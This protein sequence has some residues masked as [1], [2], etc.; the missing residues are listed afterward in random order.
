MNIRYMSDLH[1]EFGFGTSIPE[2]DILVLAGDIVDG[3][4]RGLDKLKLICSNFNHVLMVM[5]NHEHYVG[6]FDKTYDLLK[7]NLPDNV[8]IL[9]NNYAEIDGQRFIGCT[10]WSYMN[11]VDSYLAKV[12]M[13]DYSYIKI[14]DKDIYRK[15]SPK[16][17]IFEHVRS[18]SWLRSNIKEGDIVI[19]H[20]APSF[21]SCNSNYTGNS[22]YASDLSD[23]ILDTKPSVWIHGHLHEPVDYKIGNTLITSNPHGYFGHENTNS[24]NPNK[25]LKL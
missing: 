14:K 10:L 25:E 13:N 24:F 8:T 12:R 1:L 19:T 4:F 3:K 7:I 16:D 6:R 22:A 17:T 9:E 23:L 2:G 15:L 21:K 11:E 5:G 20:H 18:V